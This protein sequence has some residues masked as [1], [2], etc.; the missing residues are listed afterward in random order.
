[1]I[2]IKEKFPDK[3]GWYFC[4]FSDGTFGGFCCRRIRFDSEQGDTQ[5][6]LVI[7]KSD[8][9]NLSRS[10]DEYQPKHDIDEIV[11]YCPVDSV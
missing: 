3:P 2:N 1:M 11:S 8:I 4:K 9:C 5:T 6:K 7:V 10:T